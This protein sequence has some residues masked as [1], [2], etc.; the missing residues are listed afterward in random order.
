MMA[1]SAEPRINSKKVA[2]EEIGPIG[3][4]MIQLKRVYEKPEAHDGVRFLIERLWPRGVRKADLVTDGWQ[5]E[6]G[7][8]GEL[9]KWFSHDPEKWTEFQHRYFAEL[10]TRPEAW[11][12]ILKAAERGRV[13]LLYSSHDTEHNNAVALKRYLEAK[14][15]H[16]SKGAAAS[17]R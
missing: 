7:P 14:V 6:A 9:R 5:K 10:D 2:P 16:T 1:E 4:T 15:A 17:H 11:A 13:T 8:S 12:P 3:V